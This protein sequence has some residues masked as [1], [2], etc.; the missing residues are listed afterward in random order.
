MGTCNLFLFNRG[1][2]CK[3]KDCTKGKDP[4]GKQAEAVKFNIKSSLRG[5]GLDGDQADKMTEELDLCSLGIDVFSGG[6]T[7]E[8]IEELL[9]DEQEQGALFFTITKLVDSG[10]K[11]DDAVAAANGTLNEVRNEIKELNSSNVG[12]FLL[13]KVLENSSP[14]QLGR[15]VYN[16][17]KAQPLK[18]SNSA[19]KV[20]L[21]TARKP[22]IKMY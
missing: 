12:N 8:A 4:E 21:K 17:P 1:S 11:W 19:R 15:P 22:N 3:S 18:T 7:E 14:N 13:G 2:S 5:I 10:M 16:G 20:F 6:A 9:G